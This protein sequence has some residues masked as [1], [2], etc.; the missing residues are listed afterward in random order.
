[1][2]HNLKKA[3]PDTTKAE[4]DNTAEAEGHSLWL[5]EIEKR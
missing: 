3:V 5:L 1:M 4:T 2:A